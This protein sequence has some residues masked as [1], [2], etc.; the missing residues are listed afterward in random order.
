[1]KGSHYPGHK[2]EGYAMDCTE[3]L[4]LFTLKISKH[5]ASSGERQQLW[6]T[7]KASGQVLFSMDQPIWKRN[8]R[9]DD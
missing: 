5:P 4:N 3:N 2:K 8:S 1:M 9:G 7:G 6:L